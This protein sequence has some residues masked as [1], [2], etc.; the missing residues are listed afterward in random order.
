MRWILLAALWAASASAQ[1]YRWT[2]DNGKVH[3]GDAPPTLNGVKRVNT[4]RNTAPQT[5][6]LAGQQ[7]A[8]EAEVERL[9]RTKVSPECQ[10]QPKD[11]TKPEMVRKAEEIRIE[12]MKNVVRREYNLGPQQ[13]FQADTRYVTEGPPPAPFK[14]PGIQVPPPPQPDRRTVVVPAR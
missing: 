8:K 6:V 3:Y 2:D 11:A 10:F 12:C 7:T 5:D 13:P 4:N 9:A 14:T 1:V